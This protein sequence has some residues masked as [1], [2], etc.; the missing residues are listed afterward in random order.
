MI[1]AAASVAA[2]FAA[3]VNAGGYPACMH[4]RLARA[5]SILG[6]PLLVL[7][8]ALVLRDGDPQAL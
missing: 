7:P 1:P 5:V 4:D 8:A 3:A 6:H 2:G